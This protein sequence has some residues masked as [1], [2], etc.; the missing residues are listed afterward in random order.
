[1]RLLPREAIG[2]LRQDLHDLPLVHEVLGLLASAFQQL[3]VMPL[4]ASVEDAP[5]RQGLRR[6]PLP[7]PRVVVGHVQASRILIELRDLSRPSRKT[8]CG[9]MQVVPLDRKVMEIQ[10]S[11]RVFDVHLLSQPSLRTRVRIVLEVPRFRPHLEVPAHQ[12]GEGLHVMPQPTV[13]PRLRIVYQLPLGGQK[14][15]V[16]SPEL[17]VVRLV[18][19][20]AVEALRQLMLVVPHAVEVVGLRILHSRAHTGRRT[21]VPQ[22]LLRVVPPAEL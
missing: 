5:Q 11:V 4:G 20:R 16:L 2:P 3:L 21:H 13:G 17:Q 10:A 19:Q 14:L 8:R 12:G 6:V 18:P 1:M 15:E 22:L 7:D 9:L